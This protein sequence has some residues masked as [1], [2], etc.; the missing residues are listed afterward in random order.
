MSTEHKARI[1]LGQGSP[2]AAGRVVCIPLG[3]PEGPGLLGV[4]VSMAACGGDC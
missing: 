2:Q 3:S 4:P 1:W